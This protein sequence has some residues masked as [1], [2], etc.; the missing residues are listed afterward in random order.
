MGKQ[1]SSGREKKQ[2]FE[3]SIFP[4]PG[5]P[6]CY[7]TEGVDLQAGSQETVNQMGFHLRPGM[8]A[9]LHLLTDEAEIHPCTYVGMIVYTYVQVYVDVYA[10]AAVWFCSS[11][12]PS[13]FRSAQNWVEKRFLFFLSADSSCSFFFFFFHSCLPSIWSLYRV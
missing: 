12:A 1:E 11:C 7:S 4:R 5:E 13:A 6:A 2:A 8:N 9:L 3:W 10:G